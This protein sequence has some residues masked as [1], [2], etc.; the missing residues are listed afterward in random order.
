MASFSGRNFTHLV[1]SDVKANG[2]G[3]LVDARMLARHPQDSRMTYDM[4]QL[5]NPE[6][7]LKNATVTDWV[8]E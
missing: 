8:G 1:L 3:G 4:F 2:A 5:G 7:S 6:L